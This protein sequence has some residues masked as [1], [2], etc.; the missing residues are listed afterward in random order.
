MG[1]QS[2]IILP[3]RGEVYLVNFEPTLG[4]EIN[5]QRPALI[6]QNDVA[7]TYSHIT[8]VAA[9]TSKFDENLY[10]TEVLVPSGE[11]GLLQDSVIILNQI[12]SVDKVRITKR[13]GVVS[14]GT[15]AEVNRAIKV[16]L[17]LINI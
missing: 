12:R 1:T 14:A 3:K 13:L 16:S 9:I 5:K 6:L 8:I 10:P 17:G 11:A 15:M 7:N 2:K 4:A